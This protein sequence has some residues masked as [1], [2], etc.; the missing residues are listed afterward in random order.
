ME[1]IFKDKKSQDNNKKEG[2]MNKRAQVTIFIIIGI[3]IVAAGILIF[4]FWP[5]ISSTLAI[6]SENP[7]VFM[8]TCL[9]DKIETTIQD[10]SIQG[11]SVN[12]QHYFIYQGNKVEYLCYQEQY[13]LTCVVQQPMLIKH[14]ESEIKNNINEEMNSCLDS[15]KA[16]FISKGYETTLEKDDFS[17]QLLP[18]RVVVITNSTFVAKKADTT[19][20]YGGESGLSVVLNNNIY[21]LG[22]IAMSIISS[23]AQYGDAETTTYMNYYHDLKVEKYKQSDGT[24]VYIL[25]DRNTE[26]KLMF[27][28]RSV[29]WPPG[30]G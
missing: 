7:E 18:K 22:T 1:R 9:Q 5:K 13:Y 20:S 28:S 27:A 23:E 16:A 15:L 10:L 2:K 11:G 6:S 30:Y 8:Q 4:L 21:E 14:I 17:V 19:Y 25:T 26:N 29:A 24:K 12:P 3:V